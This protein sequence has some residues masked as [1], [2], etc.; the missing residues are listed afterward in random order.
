[1]GDLTRLDEMHPG[2]PPQRCVDLAFNAAVGLQN[3]GHRPGDALPVSISDEDW[4]CTLSWRNAPRGSDEA[5]DPKR[6]TEDGAEAIALAVVHEAK[7]WTVR[8]R[9][10]QGQ[11]ADWLLVDASGRRIALEVGGC[12]GQDRSRLREKLDQ[13]AKCRY[14]DVRAACVVEF[15]P[16]RAYLAEVESRSP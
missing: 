4:K 14:D 15:Q 6:V 2:L 3:W 5:L 7:G 1:M 10:R 8:A 11:F 16:P 13:V 12:A 9:M